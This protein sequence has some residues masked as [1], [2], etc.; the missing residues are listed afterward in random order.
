MAGPITTLQGGFN[1]SF[2]MTGSDTDAIL[3]PI[4]RSNV[5]LTLNQPYLNSNTPPTG[6]I[7][8]TQHKLFT[9]S[10]AASGTTTFSAFLAA[11]NMLGDATAT[12][13]KILSMA[14]LL[15]TVTS[16]NGVALGLTVQASSVDVG[17]AVAT[18]LQLFL[19]DASSAFH[20]TPGLLVVCN[21]LAGTG[22]T[23]SN[24]L[25]SLLF[26][27]NDST[28]AATVLVELSGLD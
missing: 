4:G 22:F 10:V 5:G 20:L 24:S 8:A 11:A 2:L 21:D 23:V 19:L 18:A 12:F 15:P 6:T 9:V 7:K 3:G 13:S 26:T 14:F 28:N 16:A 17:K 1:L 27:N 25:K